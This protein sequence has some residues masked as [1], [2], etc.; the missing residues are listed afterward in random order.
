MCFSSDAH[1]CTWPV[2]LLSLYTGEAYSLAS[3]MTLT[4]ENS[5]S[6]TEADSFEFSIQIYD[7]MVAVVGTV[8]GEFAYPYI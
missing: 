1:H 4:L 5:V 2:R 7:C 3:A 8:E 6:N